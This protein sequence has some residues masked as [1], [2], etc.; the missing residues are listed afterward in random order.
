MSTSAWV[1]CC[2]RKPN[3]GGR[4]RASAELESDPEHAQALLY[5][6]DAYIQMNRL[7]DARPSWRK[8]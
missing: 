5:L 2:G 7:E 8:S 6:A 1:T 3:P 4:R